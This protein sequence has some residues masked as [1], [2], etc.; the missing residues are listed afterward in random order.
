MV[1]YDD[2]YLAWCI[3]GGEGGGA[4]YSCVACLESV[5]HWP[6]I[7][8]EALGE[9]VP[10][11]D[12]DT[13]SSWALMTL[14]SFFRFLR[15]SFR[16]ANPFCLPS[17]LPVFGLSMAIILRLGRVLLD[18]QHFLPDGCFF[19]LR[20]AQLYLLPLLA[21]MDGVCGVPPPF[22]SRPSLRPSPPRQI[23]ISEN[24]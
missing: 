16:Y 8:F 6:R 14:L 13:S 17:A 11:P 24:S 19:N 15:T 20:T 2:G 22:S 23:A 3:E 18:P 21:F 9:P 7:P 4:G 12:G 5:G 1:R 10:T